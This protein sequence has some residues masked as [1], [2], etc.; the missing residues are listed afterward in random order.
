V[1]IFL[2]D[3]VQDNFLVLQLDCFRNFPVPTVLLCQPVDNVDIEGIWST[4]KAN[5]KL[6]I[7]ILLAQVDGRGHLTKVL[8]TKLSIEV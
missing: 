6:V 7:I 1:Y 2:T 5:S 8:S 3:L 4:V